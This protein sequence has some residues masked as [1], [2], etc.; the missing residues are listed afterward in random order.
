MP[1]PPIV[2]GC[3]V[4]RSAV[5][6]KEHDL[7]ARPGAC[8]LTWC[9]QDKKTRVAVHCYKRG[10]MM[11]GRCPRL[12]NNLARRKR[13]DARRRARLAARVSNM[14]V[15]KLLGAR[16]SGGGARGGL[17][18]SGDPGTDLSRAFSG[19]GGLRISG[20]G[21]KRSTEVTVTLSPLKVDGSLDLA[22]AQRTVASS[23]TCF[24]DFFALALRRGAKQ[25]AGTI[26]LCFIVDAAGRARSVVAEPDVLGDV[27]LSR[28]CLRRL[29]FSRP[30]GGTA[31]VCVTVSL[32]R[33]IEDTGGNFCSL[34]AY[35]DFLWPSFFQ[36]LSFVL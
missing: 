8:V 9:K 24:K 29:R 7:P 27:T 15:L 28:T 16:G 4:R 31:Q 30:T 23:R 35:Q 19:A 20:S 14:G 26:G 18:G 22:D 2:K 33:K 21:K 11:R 5:V 36:P 10:R 17:I 13:W 25:R 12:K 6:F 34:V 32:Q 3:S 1:L